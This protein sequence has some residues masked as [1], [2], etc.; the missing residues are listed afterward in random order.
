MLMGLNCLEHGQAMEK[1]AHAVQTRF[2]GVMEGRGQVTV[3]GERQEMEPG[4]VVWVQPGSPHKLE[5]ISI[6]QSWNGPTDLGK[7]IWERQYTRAIPAGWLLC[8]QGGM[9]LL[10]APPSRRFSEKPAV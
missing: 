8:I 9:K 10:A 4:R 7:R 1:H 3:T 5:M 6:G 2:Y